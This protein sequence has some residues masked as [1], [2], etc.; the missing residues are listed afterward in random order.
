MGYAD[1]AK[2]MCKRP[3]VAIF[4]RFAFLNT[5][6]LLYLQAELIHLE[7]ELNYQIKLDKTKEAAEIER[8]KN[9]EAVESEL[10][11]EILSPDRDWEDLTKAKRQWKKF[12]EIREKLKEYSKS[13]SQR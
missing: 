13:I 12:G 11:H 5:K 10:P 7:I 8:H 2:L 6:N 9:Q 3:E 1:I 4:R